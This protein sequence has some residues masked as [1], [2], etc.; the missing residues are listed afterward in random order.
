MAFDQDGPRPLILDLYEDND[1]DDRFCKSL[2][3][4]L[5]E[6]SRAPSQV[7]K[8][9][10]AWVV[11]ESSRRLHEL[12]SQPD[13]LE[14]HDDGYV[15]RRSMPNASGYVE[16]FFQSF[17]SL[18][19]VFPPYHAGQTR[20]IQFVEALMAMPEHQAP[21]YLVNGSLSDV[22]MISLWADS[23]YRT[24]QFRIGADAIRYPGSDLE[25][26]GTESEARWRNYQSTM[27][28]ITMTGFSDCGFISALRDILPEGKKYPSLKVRTTSKPE[29]IG[30]HILGAA[31]WL[32]WPD[33]VRYVYR[34]CKKKERVEKNN[35]RDTW[36]MERWGIWKAQ[37]QLFAENERVD[38]RAREVAAIAVDKMR[39]A[40]EQ[41]ES[42]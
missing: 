4:H 13:L 23:G 28:R 16:T 42:Q 24:E 32:I 12:T 1:T 22:H 33:E 39:A 27:A 38:S 29:K 14:K 17:P 6:G 25:K 3:R 19:S 40:E 18:C 10:D 15:P 34:Q 36:S 20:I 7:A 2:M 31:Q 5:V 9:L 21:D 37:F 11:Q 35:P 30:G 41:D 8:D 26:P